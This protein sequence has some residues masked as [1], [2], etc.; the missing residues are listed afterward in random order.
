MITAMQGAKLRAIND[1]EEARQ[2][3]LSCVSLICLE[4]E[5]RTAIHQAVEL[6]DGV[7]QP[8]LPSNKGPKRDTL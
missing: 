4:P 2:K 7:I 8:L 6:L 5:Q 1:L 3:A